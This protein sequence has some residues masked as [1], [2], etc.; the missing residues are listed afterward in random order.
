M[1]FVQVISGR[2]DIQERV[3]KEL[4]EVVG[5]GR[6]PTVDDEYQLPYCRAFI[7]EVSYRFVSLLTLC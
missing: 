3:H 6:L 7:K 1:Y 2:P 5:Q 4:D